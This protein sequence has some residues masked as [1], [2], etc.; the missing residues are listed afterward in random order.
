MPFPPSHAF[1]DFTRGG[2]T[3]LHNVRMFFQIVRKLCIVCLI[4][5][6]SFNVFWWYVSFSKYS[7]Q[8]TW[9]VDWLQAHVQ[10][11]LGHEHDAMTVVISQNTYR[12]LPA[13]LIESPFVKN[14]I[15]RLVIHAK[16]GFIVGGFFALATTHLAA[17]L[18]FFMGKRQRRDTTV[19]GITLVDNHTLTTLLQKSGVASD[20]TLAGVP[21]IKDAE[22]AHFLIAGTPGTGKSVC[23]AE[24][25]DHIRA[26]GQRAIVYDKVGDFV[27]QY[28]RPGKDILLNPLDERAPAWDIWAECR[29]ASDYDTLAA[30]LMPLPSQGSDPF[31]VNGAR[32]IFAATAYQM[33]SR[34]DKS[35]RA[36]LQHLLMSDLDTIAALLK[37]TEAETLVSEKIE[38]TALSIKTV[39]ATYLKSLRYLKEGDTSFSIRRWVEDENQDSWLFVTSRADKHESLKPLISAWLE[40]AG[41]A[42]MSLAP[43]KNRRI[44]MSLDELPSLHRLPYLSAMLAESRKFG[45]CLIATIQSIAQLRSLYGENEA[46]AIAG[47][48]NTR[49]FFRTPEAKTAL[50]VS[51]SLGES[52]IEEAQ[53]GFSYGADSIRDGVSLQRHR[54]RRPLVMES[55][56]SSLPDLHAYLRL[57]GEWPVTKVKFQ[58][59]SR[60][61]NAPAFMPREHQETSLIL[62]T[63]MTSPSVT[64]EKN[65]SLSTHQKFFEHVKDI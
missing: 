22:R 20:I 47:L 58:Y 60:K 31:W 63:T 18:I 23:M 46:E 40:I 11:A 56:V 10:L 37:G 17:E 34:P 51:K 52:D 2:Q 45:G 19:R 28:Y 5:F 1:K 8:R 33:R 50:W 64:E 53:E 30:A 62:P 15:H 42:L 29:D 24:L 7:S 27:S 59:Q 25:L 65:S 54:L 32:T 4:S 44:W 9:L 41:N 38:K 21:L 43:D 39:L 16:D 6:L 57:P 3:T 13:N 49:L 35:M 61:A 55:E 26:K 48:C 14:E 36:L 12:V